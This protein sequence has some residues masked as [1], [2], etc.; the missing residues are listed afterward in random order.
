LLYTLYSGSFSMDLQNYLREKKAAVEQELGSVIAPE[1]AYPASIHKA[2]RYCLFAGGKRLRPIL[3]LAAAE[4]VGGDWQSILR[5]ACALEL[6]HTYSL[7]HDDL[8]AMDNDDYRRGAP[9][10]H[11]VFG[12]ALAILAGDALLTEA[13]KLL[14]GGLASGKHSAAQLLAVIELLAEACGSRGLIGGQVVDLE[15]EGKVLDEG[16]L[17][18]IH[19]HKTGRLIIASIELGARLAGGAAEQ[20]QCLR[21]YGAAIGLAFQIA[22]DILDV[23]GSSASLGKETGSDEKKQK[24]TWPALCGLAEAERRQRA[25]CEE[26]VAALAAFDEKADPLRSIARYIIERDA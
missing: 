6:I 7:V 1:S 20:L 15:S 14:A 11:M 17:D 10:T 8:P 5:E 26:A 19:R 13:F 24:A 9:T 3:A 23:V 4:A 16:V 25:L 12:E 18:Y 2:M 21:N 22:D